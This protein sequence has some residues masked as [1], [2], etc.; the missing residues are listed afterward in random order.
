MIKTFQAPLQRGSLTNSFVLH[1]IRSENYSGHATRQKK[2]LKVKT[3]R[4]HWVAKNVVE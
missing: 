2:R 4:K 1:F 3:H